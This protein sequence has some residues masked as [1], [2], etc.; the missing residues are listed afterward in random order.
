[1]PSKAETYV[2]TFW[3]VYESA[4]Q[5]RRDFQWLNTYY[6]HGY[7][8][9][10]VISVGKSASDDSTIIINGVDSQNNHCVIVARVEAMSILMKFEDKEEGKEY[11]P[12]KKIGFITD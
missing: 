11:K 4:M 10:D 5:R 2:D 6:M 7:E 1:M 12:V 3:R 8:S 9:I